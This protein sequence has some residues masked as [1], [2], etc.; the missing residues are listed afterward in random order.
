[1]KLLFLSAHQLK[2]PKIMIALVAF[3][4]CVGLATAA[5]FTMFY[6]TST[7]TVKTPDVRLGAGPDN[8]GGTTYPAATV[9]VAST[10]DFA[11]IAF[12][13]FPSAT[14]TP[15]PASYYTNLLNITNAGT[16]AHTI[17][18]ITVTDLSGAANLGNVTIYYYATQTDTPTTGT[19]IAAASLTSSSTAPVTIFT[20]TQAIAASAVQ[21]IEIVGYAASSASAESTVTFTVSIQWA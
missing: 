16:A 12:S 8:T 11:T 14:N 7:A 4:L 3:F 15:Q 13:L 5:V 18:A 10:K 1:M 20:G 2:K 6:A 21:Y 19:P 17:K 9:T